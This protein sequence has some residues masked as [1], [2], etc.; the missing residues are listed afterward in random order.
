MISK[1][2]NPLWFKTESRQL[3][4]FASSLRIGIKIESFLLTFAGLFF[5][6]LMVRELS[7]VKKSAI[8]DSRV[9]SSIN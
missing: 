3:I 5:T 2:D 7:M 6:T 4:T 9:I 1:S 8:A